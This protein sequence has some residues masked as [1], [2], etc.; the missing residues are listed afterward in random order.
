MFSTTL[1]VLSLQYEYEAYTQL[2]REDRVALLRNWLE[3][4]DGSADEVVNG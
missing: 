1:H 3:R 4:G 2:D